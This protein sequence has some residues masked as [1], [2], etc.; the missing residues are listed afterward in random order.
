MPIVFTLT[1]GLVLQ[2]CAGGMP[3]AQKPGPSSGRASTSAIAQ[4]EPHDATA[5]PMQRSAV[6]RGGAATAEAGSLRASVISALSHS[7]TVRRAQADLSAAAVD[8]KIAYS[9]YQPSLQSSA[10]VGTRDSYDYRVSLAQPLYDWG[11]TGAQVDRAE[12][13]QAGALAEYTEARET[14]ALEAAAAHIAVKRSEELIAAAERNLAVYRHFAALAKQRASGGVGDATDLELVGV[15]QGEAESALEDVRGALRKAHSVYLLRIGAEADGLSEVPELPLTLDTGVDVA[16]SEAPAVKAARA[17]EAA[18]RQAVKSEQ[19]GLLPKVSAEAFVRGDQNS[20]GADTGVGLRITGPT[21][22]GLSNFNKV[23]AARLQADSAKWAAETARRGA[24][25][26]VR[27]LL[28]QEPTLR[29]RLGILGAELKRARALRALYED[30]FKIGER[31]VADLVNMQADIFRI[32]SSRVNARYDILDLQYAAAGAVGTLLGSLQLA[33]P[34]E[35][36]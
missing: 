24:S 12:A 13:G 14:A 10:A 8:V 30:Q 22:A 5:T 32:E 18:A 23:E 34:G 4:T 3:A 11:R 9:G 20:G 17:R 21:M 28:D 16:V 6:N 1:A 31:K 33:P 36:P 19:A 27:Q 2:A 26:Q 29:R 15:R 35:A 7:S 25:L